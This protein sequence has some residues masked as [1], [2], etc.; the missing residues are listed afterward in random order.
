MIE[1]AAA[2][3]AAL[4]ASGADDCV[5]IGQDMSETNLR[6]ANNGLTTN[7]QMASRA[8]TVISMVGTGSGVSVG[9]VSAS[10][11]DIDDVRAIV[12]GS[13]RAARSAPPA[14]D[15]VPLVSPNAN[16]P[17]W[18]DASTT[19][20]VEVFA[21]LAGALGRQLRAAAAADRALFGFAEHSVTSTYL[22][23]STGVRRRFDQPA[24]R[25]ELNAKSGDFSRSAW[26]GIAT[27]DFTDVDL[28]ERVDRLH[29]RLDWAARSIDLPAGRYE[30]LLPPSAV[31]DLMIGL[32]WG[33][34]SRDAEEGRSVFS[35]GEAGGTRIG[36]RL[37]PLPVNLYSDAAIA[38]I[39][40]PPFEIASTSYAGVQSVFDNG[41]PIDRTDWITEGVL[42]N[43]A[44]SRAWAA[45]T[46]QP[47]RQF[48]DNLVMDGG[49][50][51]T[52]ED[53]VAETERG[54]L[55]TTLW[56][57]RTVDPQTMLVTGLT[58]DGV[59]L[60]ENGKVQGAVNNFRF[61]ESPVDLLARITQLGASSRT[62]P[63]E[64][65]DF[66]PRVIMPPLRVPDFNMSTVSAAS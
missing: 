19:T 34:G 37:S 28:A 58:R 22:A 59:Y 53:M 20:S 46:D 10:V 5:V 15:V 33:A 55:L 48:L 26:D 57:I 4:S 1:M 63:R 2:V 50:P 36:D 25:L 51:S 21:D 17:G 61:N 9:S 30:T 60:V 56:Y 8:L 65:S 24:G 18:G 7:G 38:A 31:A 41:A 54:L 32:Y 35:A 16:D 42:T 40:C 66:F 62:L 45:D 13:E 23:T 14:D 12:A 64:W 27:R 52:I 29:G 47:A 11:S 6:W 49:S 39:A 3:E 44:R 43:L